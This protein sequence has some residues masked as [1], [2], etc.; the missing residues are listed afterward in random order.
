ME[1]RGFEPPTS[2]VRG[3]RS[4][5]LSYVP[6]VQDINYTFSRTLWKP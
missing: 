6:L 4:P 5:G 1:T 3:R 2:A